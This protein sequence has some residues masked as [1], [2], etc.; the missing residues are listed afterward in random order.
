MKKDVRQDNR[1]RSSIARQ[2]KIKRQKKKIKKALKM[3]IR[4]KMMKRKM[5]IVN[6]KVMLVRK[7]QLRFAR[8]QG[9]GKQRTQI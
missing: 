6:S 4:A 1:H 5:T 7:K 2:I 3:V 8:T 9:T